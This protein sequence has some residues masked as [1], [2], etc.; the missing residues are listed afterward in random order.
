MRFGFYLP[1]R[2]PVATGPALGAFVRRGEE[3][4]FDSVMIADHLVF[5]ARVDSPYPYTLS[6]AFPGQGDALD[7]ISLLTFAAAAS[8]KLRLVTSVMIVPLRNPLATAKALA[9]VDV[10]SGGRLTVGVGVGWLREEFEAMAAPDFDRRGRSTDEFVAIYRR[11]W[12]EDPASFEGEFYRFDALHCLPHPIQR[13]HPPIWIGG[14]SRA[15]LRRVARIGD[16][17]HPV[18]ATPTALSSPDDFSAALDDLRRFCDEEGR[19]FDR[20][21]VSFKAPTYDLDRN[22]APGAPGVAR[23][24]FTGSAEDVAADIADYERRGAHEVVFDFR[25]T[26][27][28]ECIER[29]ERFASEIRP[30]L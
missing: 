14:H 9:T 28:A 29:M 24:P 27:L 2:G 7:L 13:P 26:T 30:L 20:L 25:S 3:L 17:W 5:P 8:T 6:G 12:S 21:T 4:G 1:T 16:G 22:A 11:L 10:L 19:D 15:A 18:G 23:R